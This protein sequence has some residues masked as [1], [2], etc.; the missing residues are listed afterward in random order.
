MS[1]PCEQVCDLKSQR[2]S[3]TVLAADQVP[4]LIMD[5]DAETGIDV[6]LLTEPLHGHQHQVEVVHRR[7][8]HYPV[9]S[10][11]DKLRKDAKSLS[12]ISACRL[13]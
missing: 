7:A 5:A 3:V 9:D 2:C 4:Y 11:G 10:A 6:V 12:S 8:L 13:H 1:A